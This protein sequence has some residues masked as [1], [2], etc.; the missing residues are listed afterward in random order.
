MLELGIKLFEK[1][2]INNK[3]RFF[4]STAEILKGV[5]FDS[6]EELMEC[7]KNISVGIEIGTCHEME[8]A[9]R[10]EEDLGIKVDLDIC[11]CSIFHYKPRRLN[12]R[13][14]GLFFLFPQDETKPV[15]IYIR[16]MSGIIF[17]GQVEPVS[18]V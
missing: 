11:T 8:V 3:A 10:A 9:L 15:D 7:T 4:E 14:T 6:D 13:A 16:F 1:T 5:S 17:I 18:L 12:G 2:K